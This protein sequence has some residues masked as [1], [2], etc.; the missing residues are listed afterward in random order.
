MVELLLKEEL[1]P[2]SKLPA[3][4][5]AKLKG[6]LRIVDKGKTYGLFLDKDAVEELLEDLEYSS[7]EF[8]ES[9]EKSRKSGRVSGAKVKKELGL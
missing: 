5:R 6:V 2:L 1:L 9:L 7:P 4:V 8:L 3:S